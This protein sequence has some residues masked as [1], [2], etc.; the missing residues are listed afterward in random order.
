MEDFLDS[1]WLNILVLVHY[2]KTFLDLIFAPLNS[3]GPAFAIFIIAFITVIITKI[4]T[5]AFIT[6]RYKVL[7]KNFEY[8]YNMRQKAMKCEDR[9]K[10]KLLAKNIDQAELNKAYYD[11]FFEGFLIRLMTRL[12][13]IL[14]FLAYVNEAYK[15]SNLL[16]LFGREYVFK[17]RSYNGEEVVIGAVFWFVIS[18][19]LVFLGWFIIRKIWSKYFSD[20]K[21]EPDGEQVIM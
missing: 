12:L 3:L 11:Y 17:F 20:E 21:P 2:I 14:S 5:K 7:K 18:I 8:W 16:K 4:L 9:E 1:L 6:K 10:A 13:P 19:F 15:A